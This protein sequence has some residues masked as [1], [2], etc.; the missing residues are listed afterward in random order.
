MVGSAIRDVSTINKCPFA[1]EM[2]GAR[3][4]D[5]I[6]SVASGATMQF[7][8]G[9]SSLHT[10]IDG[11]VRRLPGARNVPLPA[12]LTV[13]LVSHRRRASGPDGH[14]YHETSLPPIAT[15]DS[16]DSRLLPAVSEEEVLS[17][18]AG[19]ATAAAPAY[20]PSREPTRQ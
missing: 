5:V 4:I 1:V 8:S 15:F 13:S 6:S 2:R 3:N 10:N 14:Q 12:A 17:I 18:T 11:M 20:L 7:L 9:R 16:D 19:S